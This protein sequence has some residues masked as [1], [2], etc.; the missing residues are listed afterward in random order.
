MEGVKVSLLGLMRK[1]TNN[2]FIFPEPQL[3]K[4][5]APCSWAVVLIHVPLS[6]LKC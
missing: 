6:H 5:L 1:S 4:S 3:R 2:V